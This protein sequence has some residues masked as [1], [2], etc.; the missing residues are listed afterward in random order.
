M[1][2]P[3]SC[4]ASVA[5]MCAMMSC[6]CGGLSLSDALLQQPRSHAGSRPGCAVEGGGL[7]G[8]GRQR[9]HPLRYDAE[10]LRAGEQ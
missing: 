7:L 9:R 6:G 1:T 4:L 10:G 2:C 3:A 5:L 8:G